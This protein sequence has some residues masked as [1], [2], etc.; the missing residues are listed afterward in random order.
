MEAGHAQTRRRLEHLVVDHGGIA[1]SSCLSSGSSGRVGVALSTS[2]V[3][4]HFSIKLLNG[5]LLGTRLTTSTTT[6]ATASSLLASTSTSRDSFLNGRWLGLVLLGLGNAVGK[7]GRRREIGSADKH[8]HTN[9][10]V[11]D[12]DAIQ[13]AGG[14]DSLVVLVPDDGGA[15]QA[16]AIWSILH[17]DLLWP[18]QSNIDKVFLQYALVVNQVNFVAISMF[19]ES[20]YVVV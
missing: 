3:V 17:E 9:E 13:G 10:A 5:L 7:L 14:L 19:Y 11:V 4:D 12:L 2:V 20:V 16:A 6:A 8:L 1:T 18:T 15:S